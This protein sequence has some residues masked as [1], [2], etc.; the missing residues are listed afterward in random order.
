M[1]VS[2]AIFRYH[3]G[4]KQAFCVYKIMKI[5]VILLLVLASIIPSIVYGETELQPIQ[6]SKYVASALI[7]LRDANENLVSVT[8]AQ[9]SKYLVDSIVDE[10]LDQYDVKEIVEKDGKRYELRQIVLTEEHTKDSYG[11]QSKLFVQDEN[12]NKVLIFGGSDHAFLVKADDV[13]TIVW[14]ILRLAS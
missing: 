3:T 5:I 11:F 12:K 14:N 7:E 1:K 6:G 9:A 4:Y 8:S 10:F 2:K 13:S